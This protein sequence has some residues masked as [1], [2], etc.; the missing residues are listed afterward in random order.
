MAHVPDPFDQVP[1][2]SERGPWIATSLGGAWS[3]EN[4]RPE[5]ASIID[6]SA[7]LSRCCRYS[8]QIASDV[9]FLAVSE[10]SGVMMHFAVDNGI[11]K[12]RED[13]LA[14]LLHDGSEAFFGDMITPL[15][16][17][18]PEFKLLEDRCQNAINMAFGTTPDMLTISYAEIKAIDERIRIDERMAVI[19]DPA[20]TIAL[21]NVLTRNP[22]LK[23]LN[24]EIRGLSP[25]EARIEFLE[26]FLWACDLTPLHPETDALLERHIQDAKAQ[27]HEMGVSP[28]LE[29]SL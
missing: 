22:D 21:S 28:A 11:A 18:I 17:L 26:D 25:R 16:K 6:I 4:P 10:H 1:P 7:G 3:I 29:A 14:F 19:N 13:A 5:D 20:R 24:R 23:P 12:C 8:G 2:A 15:K 27:L 9:D